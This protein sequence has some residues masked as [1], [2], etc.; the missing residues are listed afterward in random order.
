[1]M[2]PYTT[3]WA[4]HFHLR[5]NQFRVRFYLKLKLLILGLI[6]FTLLLWSTADASNQHERK[7]QHPVDRFR[8]HKLGSNINYQLLNM[9]PARMYCAVYIQSQ[10]QNHHLQTDYKLTSFC[11]SCCK[12]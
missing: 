12:G 10:L 3:T 4:A 2:Q 9:H 7:P 8:K 1:M 5:R 11:Y 6:S